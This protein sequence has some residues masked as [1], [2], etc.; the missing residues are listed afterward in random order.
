MSRPLPTGGG[1]AGDDGAADP[2]L[3]AA[4][5]ADDGSAAARVAVWAALA[6]ARVFL[7]LTAQAVAHE[8]SAATGLV[9]ESQAEMA[10]L[11]I[12]GPSGARALPA[13]LDGHAVQR[14]RPEARPVPVSGPLACRTALDD[15]ADALLL[16]PTGAAH[17]VWRPELVELA[18]GRVPVAGAGLSSRRAPAGVLG[19]PPGLVPPELVPPELMA[20][21]GDAVAPE[22]EVQQAR[23]LEG[24]DGPVLG[25]STSR[26]LAPEELAALAERVRR[27]LGGALPPAGLDLAAVPPGGPG[28]PVP[29][30]R[31]PARWWRRQRRRSG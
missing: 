21:L 9:Q 19:A 11:S 8:V 12:A 1:A 3:S 28:T 5:A 4:L 25:L 22:A 29:L 27:R 13:F 16:E 7:A 20:A 24:P 30:V 31:G 6:D 14:W 17:G 2:R 10:L 15:G 23:L 26:E 18:A